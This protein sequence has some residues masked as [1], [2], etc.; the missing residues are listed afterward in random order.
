M[1][2]IDEL[3]AR[4]N[5]I[6][7][8]KSKRDLY[9]KFRKSVIFKKNRG[10]PDIFLLCVVLGIK[11]GKRKKISKGSTLFRVYE[12]GNDIWTVLS[13][14]YSN[15]ESM[16]VFESKEGVRMALKVCEEYANSGIDILNDMMKKPKDFT[17][18]LIDEISKNRKK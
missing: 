16:N 12:L 5:Y 10:Y 18:D 7:I 11:F 2:A 14:G 15:L 13:I 9:E 8:D 6:N 1:G 4:I 17:I 3:I